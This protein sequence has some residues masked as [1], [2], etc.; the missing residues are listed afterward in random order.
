MKKD[1][2][3]Y[4]TR[5]IGVLMEKEI[6]TPDQYPLSLNAL[7]AGC[8]QKSNRH[9]VLDL[10]EDTV[11]ETLA[12]LKDKGLVRAD[13]YK[14][15]VEK[16]AHRFCNSE[17]GDLR[18]SPQEVAVIVELMVRG[19]Q[20]PGELRARAGRLAEFA[21]VETVEQVLEGL[22]QHAKGPWV[23]QLPREPGRRESR[24]AHLFSE[25]VEPLPLESEDAGKLTGARAEIADLK[26]RVVALE[27]E[28]ESLKRRL[29]ALG[30]V[31]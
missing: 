8:N 13:A 6:A 3:F 20:T 1:L 4:E 12:M 28:N 30:E 2:S 24:Y 5:V 9:P 29:R 14:S 23:Q 16:Y 15:R 19:P 17:F 31:C 21:S 27:A 7:T 25:L 18:F 10:S 26:A 22:V 11:A